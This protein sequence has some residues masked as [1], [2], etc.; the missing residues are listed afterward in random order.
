MQD[1]AN[2]FQENLGEVQV[3]TKFETANHQRIAG[4]SNMVLQCT[5]R[6][7]PLYYFV[8]YAGSKAVKS[9]KR[10]KNTKCT[11]YG[12]QYLGEDKGDLKYLKHYFIRND[13]IV[14]VG[15]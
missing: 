9:T 14:K 15:K 11:R 4:Y 13:W 12:S 6:H 7:P 8:Q 1:I 2:I 5:T 3:L 10:M